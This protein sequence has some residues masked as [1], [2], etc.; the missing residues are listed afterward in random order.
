[1]LN[2]EVKN[3]NFFEFIIFERWSWR[4]WSEIRCLMVFRK[5]LMWPVLNIWAKKGNPRFWRLE[6]IFLVQGF[7]FCVFL[8]ISCAKECFDLVRCSRK[9]NE[10]ISIFVL[11]GSLPNSDLHASFEVLQ[12][13]PK[14]SLINL[15]CRFSYGSFFC[16][17]AESKPQTSHP[18]NMIGKMRLSNSFSNVLQD[19]CT[20]VWPLAD[21]LWF[22]RCWNSSELS[23]NRTFFMNV[24][25]KILQCW[26]KYP[27]ENI[28]NIHLVYEKKQNTSDHKGQQLG[29]MSTCCFCR[30]S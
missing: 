18:Y 25:Q 23:D 30:H 15:T 10:L 20:F 11:R 28:K 5:G 9:L 4:N 2:I 16:L 3:D 6:R 14:I 27:T 29:F 21:L 24:R 19:T 13:T 1:M 7:V 8:K 12:W 26:T 22:Q 17:R